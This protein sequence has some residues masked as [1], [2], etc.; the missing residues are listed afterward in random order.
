MRDDFPLLR[1]KQPVFLFQASDN[2]FYG[3]KKIGH[4]DR[5]ATVAG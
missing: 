4:D 3:F 1:I 2:T 5:I